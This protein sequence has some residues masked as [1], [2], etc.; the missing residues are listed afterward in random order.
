MYNVK[1]PTG[2]PQ[3]PSHIRKAKRLR[4]QIEER[5]DSSA[6]GDDAPTANLGIDDNDDN[7][8]NAD[9]NDETD[10]G[11]EGSSSAGR[12][13]YGPSVASRPMVRTPRRSATSGGG[14]QDFAQVLMASLVARM[15][16]DT[17]DREERRRDQQQQRRDQQMNMAMMA[18]MMS[19]VSA[20]N[21]SAANLRRTNMSMPAWRE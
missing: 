5:A 14:M 21:P 3:C 4:V 17:V 12:V 20:A 6:L 1:V 8:D 7:D 15:E 9:G 16:Q 2:N 13:L 19:M 10:D 18:M 11:E